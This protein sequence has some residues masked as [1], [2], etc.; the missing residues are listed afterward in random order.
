MLQHAH[1]SSAVPSHIVGFA[2]LE[3]SAIPAINAVNLW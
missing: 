2:S 3:Y 1:G